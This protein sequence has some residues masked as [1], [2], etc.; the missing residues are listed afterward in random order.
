MTKIVKRLALKAATAELRLD[1]PT[2][3][4]V[5]LPALKRCFDD[6]S[7]ITG[8]IADGDVEDWLFGYAD[9]S[10]YS[11]LQ[12]TNNQSYEAGYAFGYAEDQRPPEEY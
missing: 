6:V 7:F 5:S 11:N 8:G 10:L 3:F 4:T 1:G 9:S 12:L 2:T